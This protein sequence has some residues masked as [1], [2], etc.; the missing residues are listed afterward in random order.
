MSFLTSFSMSVCS[1]LIP[2]TPKWAQIS[3]RSQVSCSLMR[4]WP[5]DSQKNHAKLRL[6]CHQTKPQS[7]SS[8]LC[9]GFMLNDAAS[10]ELHSNTPD[11]LVLI[12]Q[13]H[14]KTLSLCLWHK[15][16]RRESI[17]CAVIDREPWKHLVEQCVSVVPEIVKLTM[18]ELS[19]MA[20]Q[21]EPLG[22]CEWCNTVTNVS[23]P[24]D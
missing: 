16:H 3:C 1:W 15:M 4:Q 24:G 12:K 19:F 17:N 8:L 10:Q 5:I 18:N 7:V 6:D 23:F 2:S 14:V 21:Q 11:G 13:Q 20:A 9:V 22:H